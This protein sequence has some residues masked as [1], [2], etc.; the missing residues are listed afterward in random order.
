MNEGEEVSLPANARPTAEAIAQIDSQGFAPQTFTSTT[1]KNNTA[2]SNNNSSRKYPD[3]NQIDPH[4]DAIFGNRMN[5]P[6]S[7]SLQKSTLNG[8]HMNS[9]E[10][11]LFGRIFCVDQVIRSQR[12][13]EKLKFLREKI[14]SEST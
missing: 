8:S 1:T 14:L 2:A 3:I 5:Q 10:D 12:W 6:S 11:H 9:N 4:E 13:I 7:V